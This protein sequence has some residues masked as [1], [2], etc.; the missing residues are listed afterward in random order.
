MT[1]PIPVLSTAYFPP[2]AWFRAVAAA[3]VVYLEACEHYQ[4]QSW[5]NRALITTADGPLVLSLPILKAPTH[6]QPIRSSMIDLT[7][8]WQQ[9]HERALIAAYRSSPFFEYYIDEWWDILRSGLPSL[10]D[11]NLALVRHLLELLGLN[12][13]IRLTETYQEHYPEQEGWLDLRDAF[14]PKRPIPEQWVSKKPYYQVFTD[15]KGFVADLSILD[16][17]SNEGPDALS[18]LR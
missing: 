12:T 5:R 15:R 14:H 6:F 1:K 9:Q 2:I 11:T 3:D 7:K 8:P 18:Y 16:L 10:F 17:L 13:E 4:K